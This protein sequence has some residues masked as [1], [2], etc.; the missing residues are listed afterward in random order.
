MINSAYKD[1]LGYEAFSNTA[2]EDL[3][4]QVF[5]SVLKNFWK[6]IFRM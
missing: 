1:A 3:N 2:L 6:M 5:R 4:A